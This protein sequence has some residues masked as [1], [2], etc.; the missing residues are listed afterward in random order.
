MTVRRSRA[1][2][3]RL[4]GCW[5]QREWDNSRSTRHLALANLPV[6]C[7]GCSPGNLHFFGYLGP[8]FR[9]ESMKRACQSELRLHRTLPVSAPPSSGQTNADRRHSQL[10]TT[11]KRTKKKKKG[12]RYLSYNRASLFF[13]SS[14]HSLRRSR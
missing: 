13:R 10:L 8:H 6:H 4:R 12:T 11:T 3:R 14:S 5:S 1:R 7:L 2:V 9:F